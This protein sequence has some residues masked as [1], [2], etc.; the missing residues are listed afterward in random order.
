MV[1]CCLYEVIYS[2]ERFG[3][4]K[5][6]HKIVD[7]TTKKIPDARFKSLRIGLL[8]A[9]LLLLTAPVALATQGTTILR[10][11]GSSTVGA[12][13]VPTLSKIFFKD[14]G[15]DNVFQVKGEKG[16]QAFVVARKGDLLHNIEILSTGTA[17]A[18]ESLAAGR[19]DVGMA[20]RRITAAEAGSL[21]GMGDMT[22]H[23]N[24]HILAVDGLAV[25]V[26]LRNPVNELS[27]EQL[28]GIFSGKIKNWKSVGGKAG[29]IHVYVRDDKSGTY[30]AFRDKVLGKAALVPAA[31]RFTSSGDLSG[32]VT[33][34]PAGIGVV[35]MTSVLMA[36]AIAV[37]PSPEEKGG[38]PPIFSAHEGK[39]PLARRLHLYVAKQSKN[40][41]A[42]KFAE[43]AM[44]YKGQRTVVLNGFPRLVMDMDEQEPRPGRFQNGEHNAIYEENTLGA[45][46]VNFELRFD[47]S[48]GRLDGTSVQDLRRF[49]D[50]IQSD[51]IRYYEAVLVGIN[52]CN[53]TEKVYSDIVGAVGADNFHVIPQKICLDYAATG[54]GKPLQPRIE[55]WM[56]SVDD[57]A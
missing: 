27:V 52:A 21:K 43:F 11:H 33:R 38:L 13:L 26:N 49:V 44:S 8:A 12:R 35:G 22:A 9:S 15:Y 41:Y 32:A 29:P 56:R 16:N 36:R 40:K 14:M 1:R 25:I 42:R 39:Y 45:Q 37:K 53:Q 54:K 20:S 10:I 18:F 30:D 50:Y 48:D 47:K 55:V 17:G 57:G 4:K 24:E 2:S 31:K 7:M 51:G 28:S 19:C 23:G 46:K 34:D 3:K 5:A 6:I